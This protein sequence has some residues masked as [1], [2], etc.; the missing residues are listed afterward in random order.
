MATMK[1]LE[2]AQALKVGRALV[3]VKESALPG[4]LRHPIPCGVLRCRICSSFRLLRSRC[5][6][7]TRKM[8]SSSVHAKAVRLFI[9]RYLLAWRM[10]RSIRA[11]TRKQGGRGLESRYRTRGC[12]G[13]A[14]IAGSVT[15]G[16]ADVGERTGSRVVPATGAAGKRLDRGA[17]ARAAP[18][19][20]STTRCSDDAEPRPSSEAKVAENGSVHRRRLTCCYLPQRRRRI[21]RTLGANRVDGCPR[22]ALTGHRTA[23]AVRADGEFLNSR[24]TS[25]T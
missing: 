4:L 16:E 19:P 9:R 17:R 12:T 13:W 14:G 2:S 1:I 18:C 22:S 3:Y 8:L 20:S 24:G 25:T 6:M 10:P 21:W 7:A 23:V 11:E 5:A 15:A